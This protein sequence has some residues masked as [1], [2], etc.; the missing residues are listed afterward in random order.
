MIAGDPT[1]GQKGPVGPSYD[2]RLRP[3]TMMT[4]DRIRRLDVALAAIIALAGA[5]YYLAYFDRRL[6]LLDEGYLVDP[7]MRVLR[8]ETP[9]LDFHH[10]YAPGRFYLFALLLAAVGPNFL[11]VRLGLAFLNVLTGAF[12]YLTARRL[13][14]RL[15][16]LMVAAVIV[17]APGRWHKGFFVFFPILCLWFGFRYLESPRLRRAAAAGRPDGFFDLRPLVMAG[18]RAAPCA[19]RCRPVRGGVLAGERADVRLLRLARCAGIGTFGP[20]PFG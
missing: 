19:G 14:D 1:G 12:A 3:V 11:A 9:Y 13:G 7:V 6:S 8:G 2:A 15:T 10:A 17:I 18:R 4:E 5:A 20:A 16:S